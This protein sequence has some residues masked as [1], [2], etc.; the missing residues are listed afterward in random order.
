M[1]IG[2]DLSVLQS[3]HRFRGIGSVI[4]NFIN[5]LSEQERKANQFVFFVESENEELAYEKLDLRHMSY[6]TRYIHNKSRVHLPGKLNLLLKVY[7]KTKGY[8]EYRIGDPRMS[9]AM[10]AD[11]DRFMQF[12]QGRK[13]PPHAGKHTV[14]VLYDL[15]PYVLESDY[16]WSYKTA[17]RNQRSIKGSIKLTLQRYQYIS[18]IKINTR[19]ARTLIAIS[20]HTEKDFVKYLGA[21]PKKIQLARL[22]INLP[23]QDESKNVPKFQEY[24]T[25]MWG[26]LKQDFNPSKKPF[27]LF[28]GGTDH[29]R[30]MI[31]LLAAYNNLRARG[32]D[33]SLVMAGDSLEGIDDIKNPAMKKYMEQNTSYRDD[34]KLLGYVSNVQ[35]DW[36]YKNTTAFV[37]PSIYEGFGLPV[38]E[39]MVHGSPVITFKNTSIVEVAGTYALYA[40]DYLDIVDRVEKLLSNPSYAAT[41][42][43]QGVTHA[44][45]FT[46]EKTTKRILSALEV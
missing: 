17:R 9:K 10:L 40:N 37:F 30:K 5:N 12:D 22:G 42:T 29:R 36:L 2:I 19:R 21:D 15:I 7:Y 35:R 23:T 32:I 3:D 46:W 1:K 4:I 20:K 13:L 24:K 33:I 34:I 11:I 14:L 31:E 26:S 18:R 28:M 6:E 44:Q 25:T 41:I 39:A 38:L 16:L 45:Q 27:L 43:K 8:I